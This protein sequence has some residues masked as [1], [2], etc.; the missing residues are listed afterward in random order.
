MQIHLAVTVSLMLPLPCAIGQNNQLIT[1]VTA[2]SAAASQAAAKGD[3]VGAERLYREAL[4][5]SRQ[6][7][8]KSYIRKSNLLKSVADFYSSES[9]PAE[10]QPLLEERVALLLEYPTPPSL[11]LGLALFDLQS[12]FGA[13]QQLERAEETAN[14]AVEFY[15]TCFEKSETSQICDRRMADVQT[16]MASIFFSA[17]MFERSEPWL[18]RVVDR[19]DENVRPEFMLMAIRA[20]AKILEAKGEATESQKLLTRAAEFQK[21]HPGSDKFLRT[22]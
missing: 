8:K 12:Y 9:K 4:Q 22:N 7:E 20:Y 17:R 11:E 21:R 3:T 5:L 14:R 13:T 18:K 1:R 6:L 15:R 16:I 10:A 2:A 19:P